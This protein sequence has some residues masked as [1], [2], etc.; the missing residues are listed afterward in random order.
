MEFIGFARVGAG[1]VITRNTRPDSYPTIIGVGN[2]VA[3]PFRATEP[4]YFDA[5]NQEIPKE[6]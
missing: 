4:R 1:V 3:V 5:A 6:E 2:P